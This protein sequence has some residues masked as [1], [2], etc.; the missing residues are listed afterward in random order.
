MPMTVKDLK[1]TLVG[2]PD[3]MLVFMA[4]DEEGN[5]YCP[6]EDFTE[7]FQMQNEK[8]GT[9]YNTIIFWPGWAGNWDH[10]SDEDD[11]E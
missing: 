4:E 10:I 3:D 6:M 5:G 1:D 9:I 8:T 2:L 11:E 7:D